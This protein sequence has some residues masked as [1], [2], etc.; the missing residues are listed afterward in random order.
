MKSCTKCG[1]IKNL[2]CFYATGRVCKECKKEYARKYRSSKA[3][4]TQS[5]GDSASVRTENIRYGQEMETM[6]AEVRQGITIMTAE[7]RED[8]GEMKT[9]VLRALGNI[10]GQLCKGGQNSR[11]LCHR[12]DNCYDD[13][14]L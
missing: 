5:C 14:S 11:L 13:A 2:D 1:V 8:I 9:E 3:F 12:I 4:D 10:S 6:T 7:V